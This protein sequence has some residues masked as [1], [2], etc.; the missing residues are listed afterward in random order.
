[1]SKLSITLSGSFRRNPDKL[2]QLYTDLKSKFEVLS[3]VSIDWVSA[4]QGFV[5]TAKQQKQSILE[6]ES[7]H[8][9]A[10]TH[11]DLL[12][13]HAP[14]GYVG[15]S[16]SLEIGFAHALG[17]PILADSPPSDATLAALISGIYQ[18]QAKAY[19]TVQAGQGVAGLQRYLQA[20]SWS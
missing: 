18:P 17:I 12:I 11:S 5:K 2:K 13:F 16:G 7:G 9:Q 3:P 20:H 10:I 1:M 6:V 19:P 8:L 14:D 15:L 4:D